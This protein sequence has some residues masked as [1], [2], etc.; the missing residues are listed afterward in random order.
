MKSALQEM[1]KK[2]LKL[3]F[4]GEY[5]F[6]L[7]GI[8]CGYKDYK[9]CFELNEGLKLNFQRKEDVNF[10]AGRPG[11]NT[12]HSYYESP[13]NDFETYHILSNKD[14]AGTGYFIPENRNIDFFLLITDASGSYDL[15]TLIADIRRLDIV[16]GVYE[17]DPY[18]LKSADSFLIFLES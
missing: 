17:M 5:N 4:E 16:S 2:I 11:S 1:S 6:I 15:K 7:L 10:P 18:E 13:G 14:K 3:D 12:R 9:L 8:I